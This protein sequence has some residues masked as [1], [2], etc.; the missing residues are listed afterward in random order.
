MKKAILIVLLMVTAIFN[1]SGCA[2]S[3][4]KIDIA[5]VNLDNAAT[6]DGEK[7]YCTREQ[8]TGTH[9]KTTTCLT[10]AEKAAGR[11]DSEDYVNR[12]KRMPEYRSSE[13]GGG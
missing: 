13:P 12:L 2:S 10:R 7:L 5:D 11:R 4:Q 8:V 1:F 6:K 9:L 3:Q